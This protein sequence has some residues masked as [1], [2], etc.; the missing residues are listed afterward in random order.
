MKHS[1]AKVFLIV[2]LALNLILIGIFGG[3]ML[4]RKAPH[5]GKHL[6]APTSQTAPTP[7]E[8]RLT[9]SILREIHQ[10][11]ADEREAHR[12]AQQ[13]L[14]ATLTAEIL[15]TPLAEAQFN[16]LRQTEDA[17]RKRMQAALLTKIPD[18]PATQR[19]NIA[20]H[21]IAGERSG[22][23]ARRRGDRRRP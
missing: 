9:S 5:G 13:A 12:A 6:G 11:A 10:N 16:T 14:Y 2:S 1:S 18:L 21:L 23:R 20:T 4:N 19:A 7:A 3:M 8:R 15:D 22:S 17:M